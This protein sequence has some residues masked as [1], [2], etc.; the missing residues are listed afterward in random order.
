MT[1][2]IAGIL[3]GEDD[4]STAAL[5]N[6]LAMPL[7]LRDLVFLGEIGADADLAGI[8]NGGCWP[9]SCTSRVSGV[10]LVTLLWRYRWVEA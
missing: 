3:Q 2:A 10:S 8:A 7:Y 5:F 4:T 1:S 6:V 9:R